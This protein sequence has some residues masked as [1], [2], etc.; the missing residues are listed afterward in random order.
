MKR[1]VL[2]LLFIPLLIGINADAYGQEIPLDQE[3]LIQ[4]LDQEISGESAKRNLEYITRLHRMRGSRDYYEAMQFIMEKLKAYGLSDI[5]HI[6][7][8]TDGK[9]FYGTQKSRRA[10]NVEFAE[11]WELD[12]ES[13]EPSLKIGDWESVPLSLAQDSDSGEAVAELVDLGRGDAESD[14][15][16]IDVKGKFV[17][18]SLQPG[19]MADLAVGKYGA[20]GIISYAQNQVTAW[21]KED[22]NLVRWGHME[23]FSDIKTFG[24]MISLKKAR[25][26]QRRLY[27]GEKIMLSGKVIAGQEDGYYDVLTAVIPGA[28]PSVAG[29]EIVYT[30]H[31]DHPR[32]GAN[33]NASGS[34]TILEIARALS[35]LIQDGKLE[36]PRRTLRFIW[37]P[38]IEGTTS[39]LNF[40]PEFAEN[41][42]ANIHLDMVGGGPKT[43]AIFHVSKS[44]ES[45]PTYLNTVGEAFGNFV[46]ISSD[47]YAS[48]EGAEYPVVSREGGKEALHAVLGDFNMGSD[49]QVFSEGSWSIPTMYLHD[50]P[51]RYIH[52]TGDRPE[53]IDPTKLK[54]SAFIGLSTGYYVANLGEKDLP[55]LSEL[56]KRHL[57]K[58]SE[59]M[60]NF[61]KSVDDVECENIKYYFWE[62]EMMKYESL[63]KLTPI[64]KADL[65]AYGGYIDILKSAF[66]SGSPKDASAAY[67]KVY[68]RNSNIKGPMGVFGYN[69]FDDHF[70]KSK[71]RPKIL[72][73]RGK[74]GAG[75][76]YSYEVLNYVNGE[77]T[78]RDIRNK[79]SAEL[80]PVSLEM[81]AEYLDALESINVIQSAM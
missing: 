55:A 79:V 4:A 23:T 52:T 7:I 67:N 63:G 2:L 3:N 31:L 76:E 45:V 19:S 21:W 30:C 71:P 42:I 20:A 47:L 43:K 37:S 49:H 40:R 35:K 39:L 9:T 60:L 78:V 75:S 13:K 72:R 80:G 51:D 10:W 50:W 38:E 41:A 11:L 44:P 18:T 54:R 61:C 69:Y 26:Y 57:L 73:H 29:E 34:I 5:K 12:P 28:D 65:E 32:P 62:N 53:N 1:S 56:M 48:G 70:D 22:E 15:E 58:K 8:P 77:N 66:G 64:S 17:L 14:Y 46:N 59:S 36:K 74:K 27:Q 25:E 81:V 16:G 24:F 33:D 68:K 6:Q